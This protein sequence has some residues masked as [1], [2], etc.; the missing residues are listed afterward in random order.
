[1]HRR[2]ETVSGEDGSVYLALREIMRGIAFYLAKHYVSMLSCFRKPIV[3]VSSPGILPRA[4][5]TFDVLSM[6]A[7]SLNSKLLHFHRAL[8]SGGIWL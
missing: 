7:D 8:D 4:E 3:T 6:K 2:D 1:M 5:C